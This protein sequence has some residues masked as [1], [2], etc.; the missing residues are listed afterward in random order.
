MKKI[1]LVSAL[2]F[3]GTFSSFA[4]HLMG[5][6]IT[7]KH[8]ANDDY[9]VTLVV[10]RDC[11]GID[12]GTS[13]N[14]TFE[15]ANCGQNFTLSFPL[16]TTLDVSQLCG[17]DSLN[18]T[19]HGGTL[20][21]TEQWIYRDTV[22]LSPC[23]DWQIH[24]NSGTRNPAITNL[25][26]PSTQNLF[27][28]TTLNNVIGANNSSPQYLAIPTP[29][30]CTGQLNIFS[31]S[32]SDIDGDS[33]Y[34]TLAQ[35]LDTPG[36]P[37]TPIPFTA[38]YTIA[39]PIL[40]T[41]GM[42]LSQTTGEM[43]F[44][45]TV[46]QI[47]VVSIIVSEH[48]NGVLIGTQIREM[49]VVVS[50]NCGGNT[51]PSA[52]GVAAICGGN[53]GLVIDVQGPTVSQTGPN[54]FV[55]CPNDSLC[56][57]IPFSD[58]D[59]DNVTVETNAGISIPGAN[60][61]I[62][63]N[64][65]QNASLS[66]CWVPTPLDSGINV[67]GIKIE[68]DAC[69]IKAVQ[70]Y[71]YDITVYD[72]PYAGP[73][74]IICGSQTAQLQASGG[75]GY[76]WYD[77]ATGLAVPV[78]STFTCNPC[79][80]P[81]ADP[82]I[83]TTYYVV[84]SLTAACE[85]K[86]TVTINVVPDFTLDA[87]GDTALCD[88]L[89][90]QIG[91]NITSGPIG[92][93][94]FDWNNSAT[95]DNDTIQNPTASPLGTTWYTVEVESPDGCVK[96]ID[97]VQ[98]LVTPPPV[99]T[100]VPGDTTICQGESL[101]FDVS[102]SAINDDFNAGFDPTV[103][104]N[105]S[106]ASVAAP[107][108]PYDGTA[109]NFDA[110]TRE[111]TTNAINVNN[112]TTVDFC[113]WIAN[114][115]SSGACENADAGEDVVL[116]YNTGSGWVTLQTYTTGDWDSGGP[117]ANAW[118]CFSVIIPAA[119]QTASTSFQWEQIGG[120]GGTIDNWSLDNIS[121]SCGGNTAYNY[122]WAPATDLS[123]TNISNP[124]LSNA[125]TTTNYVVTIT[126]TASGCAID[127][128]QTITVVPSYTL[129][130]T[131]TDTNICLG[132]NVDFT[133]TAN[134]PGTY[135]YS[136]SPSG[137]MD[138]ATI[139]NPTATFMTPGTNMIIV[140]VDNG[141]GCQK[142]DTMYV[143]V[144]YGFAPNITMTPD[145]I[146][147]CGTDSAQLN[148]DLGGGIPAT[149]GASPST[150][151]SGASTQLTIGTNSGANTTT[152]WPAPYGNFYRNAKHQFL[153][154][155]A[156]LNAMGFNGG[157]I[158]EI[159][160]E[161]T[162]IN[163]TTTYND[164]QIKMGCTS[165]SNL[166]TWESG[167]TQVLNPVA[168]NIVLGTNTHVLDVAYEWDGVSNLVI[169]ICYDNL[170][171]TYTN[172]S[173]TPWTTT[174]FTSS[175]WYRSDSQAACPE[176]TSSGTGTE[177]P[178]TMFT[179]CPTTPDPNIYSYVWSPTAGLSDSTIKNPLASPS[180]PTTYYV[181][182]TDT[183]GGCFDMDSVYVSAG[184][185]IDITAM[186][187]D[188][189][190]CIYNNSPYSLPLEVVSI[191][192]N[193][194]YS[195]TNGA[196]LSDSTINNPTAS[197]T[198]TTSYTV[199]VS[200]DEGC[201]KDTTA[202]ITVF[203]TALPL[204]IQGDTNYCFGDSAILHIGNYDS[205][206]WSNTVD[207][208]II[209]STVDTA[210]LT[211]GDYIVTVSAN[212]CAATS[213]TV[214]VNEVVITPPVLSDTTFCAGDSVDVNVGTGY[215]SYLWSPTPNSGGTTAIANI[216]VGD[217]YFVTVDSL[218]GTLRCSA[219]SNTI[220]VSEIVA[221]SPVIIGD[222]NYCGNEGRILSVNPVY[223]SYTWSPGS[224][225]SDTITAYTVGNNPTTI[226][227]TVDSNGCSGSTSVIIT[228]TVL[229]PQIFIDAT[230]CPDSV[231]NVSYTGGPFGTVEWSFGGSDNPT[232]AGPGAISLTVVLGNCT[233]TVS[234]TVLSYPSPIANFSIA[235]VTS[236]LPNTETLFTD[237]STPTGFISS[238]DWN[239]DATGVGS[240]FSQ[241]TGSGPFPWVYDQQ[242]NYSITL[243]V[244]DNNGCHNTT[245]QDYLIVSNIVVANVIT[246]NGDGM[247]DFLVFENLDTS[248]AS[249]QVSIFNRW[250]NEV[251]SQPDYQNDWN[252]DGL[253]VGTYF[254]ILQ[255]D[256]KSGTETFKGSLNILR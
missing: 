230:V 82:L 88:Y 200:N 87:I 229:N 99:T 122:N 91:V 155:A 252:G 116:N 61:T 189:S 39:D 6:E 24:W 254:Y 201:T 226:T 171:V 187:L 49:Q 182:V 89:S 173:I 235:P 190:I 205:Y 2:I 128:N 18:S 131:Q 34:Y 111:L 31:H 253:S 168:V 90:H 9:E 103:W 63:G 239:F 185:D 33:L 107:C 7:Y 242:G 29:Y 215:D 78:D 221:P 55:M 249:N 217:N 26:T 169:E 234:E 167:L 84:S 120:Y 19:C 27:I 159:A 164:Y 22:T 202:T 192:A 85:N 212:N 132:Q 158:T 204:L 188:T 35:P 70:Y 80:N 199:S 59:A 1:L 105:V 181:T 237:G 216:T 248:V 225:L 74:Q 139:A 209:I 69:P 222:T 113:L 14:V 50:N 92:T 228:N 138:T 232:T 183:L 12:V 57:S 86:D 207:T 28:L 210:Y 245:S 246:P 157:K 133:V 106:G 109:L 255:V 125:V 124:V 67:I 44:T 32:A 17:L 121:I 93:Y 198:S 96:K 160:W 60:V 37:G 101:N 51:P 256:F 137:I 40:T 119:A 79:D 4:S 114:D 71:T 214:T 13:Q 223:N 179:T 170:A 53:G 197:L 126:D 193:D 140:Q 8:I 46:A 184:N 68:D 102:L 224:S 176:A 250:G 145:T 220:L 247:N 20:P 196:T 110:A 45:P 54:S 163:G 154:T 104:L 150:S 123:A 156:E 72:Q 244:I 238:W 236:G 174:T 241:G 231:A 23:P 81:I 108:V 146:I 65:T 161:I 41:S 175:I 127:R 148:I 206:A 219:I 38:G 233:T 95:L 94:L 180:S 100:M 143:N 75:A 83:T 64:G 194:T 117:F 112:C 218:I 134:P 149:C 152:S 166:T 77:L 153:Y 16:I 130:T 30:M 98:I 165:T 191:G 48:R 56:F 135:N 147:S 162:Q 144:S 251:F 25:V 141:G 227:L 52:G 172:N 136:W 151:C 142:S 118:Q 115:A 62:T 203:N 58:I 10:Y 186:S 177:R 243:T 129:T 208:S 97:S 76:T 5:G 211:A 3:L 21:G 47:C 195:W 36:P 15:S 42:N 11:S 240:N 213:D 66:F 43:C 73:D 178:V